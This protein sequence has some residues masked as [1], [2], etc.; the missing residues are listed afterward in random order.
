MVFFSFNNCNEN[1]NSKNRYMKYGIKNAITVC[2][3]DATSEKSKGERK[4]ITDSIFNPLSTTNVLNIDCGFILL[5]CN[6]KKISAAT[7]TK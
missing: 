4:T 7:V 1:H 6:K 5:L 2:L 3:E